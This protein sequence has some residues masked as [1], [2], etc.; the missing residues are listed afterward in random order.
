[1]S[2]LVVLKTKIHLLNYNFY[3]PPNIRFATR[4]KM[5]FAPMIHFYVHQEYLFCLLDYGISFRKM[6][7]VCSVDSVLCAL[8]IW[9]CVLIKGGQE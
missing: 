4:I 8:K 6:C 2:A 3:L 9:I 1:M 5:C 7:F